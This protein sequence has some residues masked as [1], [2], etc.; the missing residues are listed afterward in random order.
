MDTSRI[1]QCFARMDDA[2]IIDAVNPD[3]G[4]GLYGGRTLEEV[5]QD[6]PGAQL[7]ALAEWQAHRASIQRTPITWH[8]VSEEEYNDML[9]CLPPA[10]YEPGAFLVGEPSD[11]E[12]DTGRSRF[13]AYRSRGKLYERSNRP[14]TRSEFRKAI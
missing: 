6:N 1:T 12:A 13:Q 11:H 5:Q 4:K 7:M 10:A 2:H 14:L 8:T 3:T 9:C